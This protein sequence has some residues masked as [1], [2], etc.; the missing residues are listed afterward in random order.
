MEI[1]CLP[2]KAKC[3]DE[4]GRSDFDKETEKQV[5]RRDVRKKEIRSYDERNCERCE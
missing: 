4:D 5:P 3:Q 2:A 1:Q